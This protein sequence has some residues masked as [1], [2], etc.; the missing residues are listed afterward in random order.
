MLRVTRSLKELIILAQSATTWF[1]RMC[2]RTS[3][4]DACLECLVRLVGL[5][6]NSSAGHR[7]PRTSRPYTS[8]NFS[9]GHEA[10]VAYRVLTRKHEAVEGKRD[11]S[12]SAVDCP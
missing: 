11:F 7:K 1:E 3:C 4:S 2:V 10:P 8:H 12:G 5:E 6:S 9:P